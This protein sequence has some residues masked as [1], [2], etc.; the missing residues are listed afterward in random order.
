MSEDLFALAEAEITGERPFSVSEITAQVKGVIEEGLPACWVEGEI[1]QYT[2]HTSGHPLRVVFARERPPAGVATVTQG[3]EMAYGLDY[4]FRHEHHGDG[5]APK[6]Y[7]GFDT[8]TID[9]NKPVIYD[10]GELKIT[11]FKVIH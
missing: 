8:Y 2:H 3:L 4:G 7:A 11:A 5:I 6:K 9:L 1:S 10:N